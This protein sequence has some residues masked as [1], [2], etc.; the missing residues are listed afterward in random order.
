MDNVRF[1]NSRSM[2]TE[3]QFYLATASLDAVIN[4]DSH[5]FPLNNR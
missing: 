5:G 4:S 1:L 3:A 2:D